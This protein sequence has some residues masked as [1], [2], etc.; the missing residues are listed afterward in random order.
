MVK[1]FEVIPE[2]TRG[3]GALVCF[4]QDDFPLNG[5]VSAIPISYL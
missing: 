3:N 1:N 4:V 5:E 2:E